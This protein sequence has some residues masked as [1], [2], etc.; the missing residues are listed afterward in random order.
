M[1]ISQNCNTPTSNASPNRRR[2]T[3]YI[4]YADTQRRSRSISEHETPQSNFQQK[5][6]TY[7]TSTTAEMISDL[8]KVKF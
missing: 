4:E 6:S 3:P 7:Q 5:I 2:Q 8:V 1:I